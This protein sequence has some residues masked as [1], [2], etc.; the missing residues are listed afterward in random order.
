MSFSIRPNV[1]SGATGMVKMRC[2]DFSDTFAARLL[3]V[4]LIHY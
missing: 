3:A 2:K 4:I 1:E